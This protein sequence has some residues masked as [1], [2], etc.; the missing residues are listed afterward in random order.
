MAEARRW[1]CFG[2]DS[3]RIG[4]FRASNSL[5]IAAT[6]GTQFYL[7]GRP[8][9]RSLVLAGQ[10]FCK[11]SRWNYLKRTL[12]AM[13]YQGTISCTPLGRGA[14]PHTQKAKGSRPKYHGSQPV[15]HS[16]DVHQWGGDPTPGLRGAADSNRRLHWP[17]LNRCRLFDQA[18][19]GGAR[20]CWVRSPAWSAYTRTCIICPSGQR[21]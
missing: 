19:G 7:T 12:E 2:R 20:G 17:P 3:A 15:D 4:A 5:A 1:R 8:C 18:C 10:R 9:S 6:V 11:V 16:C 14:R 21:I 13:T